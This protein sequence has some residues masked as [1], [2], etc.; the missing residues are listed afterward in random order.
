MHQVYIWTLT[1]YDRVCWL[2]ADMIV[3]KNIDDV[4]HTDFSGG[5]AMAA[6][7]GCTVSASIRVW[8][9]CMC[10]ICAMIGQAV[11]SWAGLQS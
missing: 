8:G 4:F 9:L 6:A 7:P 5:M 1:S 11:A 3:T 2:D 10:A